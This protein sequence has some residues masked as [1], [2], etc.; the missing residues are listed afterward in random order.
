M[1]DRSRN[2]CGTERRPNRRKDK[3]VGNKYCPSFVVGSQTKGQPP[4]FYE[5]YTR[6]LLATVPQ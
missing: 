1:Q 6:V 2:E 4:L 3:K 5:N